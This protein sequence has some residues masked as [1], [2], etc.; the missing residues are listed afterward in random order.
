MRNAVRLLA[1]I[2]DRMMKF[3]PNCRT[4]VSSSDTRARRASFG[5]SAGSVVGGR[6]S[7]PDK[8]PSE[9]RRRGHL[10]HRRDGSSR[11][12]F[13]N[14]RTSAEDPIGASRRRGIASQRRTPAPSWEVLTRGGK[15]FPALYILPNS[16]A[17]SRRR[18]DAL[19]FLPRA[20]R[21]RY[22]RRPATGRARH[23]CQKEACNK[24]RFSEIFPVRPDRGI[25]FAGR[26]E[27][28]YELGSGNSREGSPSCSFCLVSRA[29][30]SSS[31]TES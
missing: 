21:F 26:G 16:S 18:R 3:A 2:N 9:F 20:V 4:T 25:L 22:A 17:A 15:W 1:L 23:R 13:D 12:D 31:A 29:S 6:P 28:E 7:F 30:R 11:R 14:P 27:P 10:I 19:G 5:R 24:G 8:R